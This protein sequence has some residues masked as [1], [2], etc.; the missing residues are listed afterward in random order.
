MGGL[1][2]S[3]GT[4]RK[5]RQTSLERTA[6]RRA[7]APLRA[8]SSSAQS[9]ISVR[10]RS[11]IEPLR[12]LWLWLQHFSHEYRDVLTDWPRGQMR[13]VGSRRGRGAGRARKGGAEFEGLGGVVMEYAGSERGREGSKGA[14]IHC[15][16][17]P[18]KRPK[19]SAWAKWVQDG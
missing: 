15:Q 11:Q 12:G 7:R 18:R 5:Q 10:Q 14:C 3:Q 6:A 8:Q 19:M 4:P 1:K 13:A 2:T 9:S 16:A 17:V